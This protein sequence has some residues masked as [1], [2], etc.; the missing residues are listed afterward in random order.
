MI[1]ARADVKKEHM[2]LTHWEA[3][4]QGKIIKSDVVVAK[5]YL[6]KQELDYLECIEVVRRREAG[7]RGFEAKR[8]GRVT[9]RTTG[10]KGA[11]LS[12]IAVRSNRVRVKL[13]HPIEAHQPCKQFHRDSA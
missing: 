9:E 12:G 7:C 10:L 8:E 5:N 6:A 4:A 1:V 3:A 2:G 11:N 13:A